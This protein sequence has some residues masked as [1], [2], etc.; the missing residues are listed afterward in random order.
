VIAMT[1][2]PA[3]AT[4]AEPAAALLRMLRVGVALCF[5]GHGA[6]GLMTKA[7]WVP[8]FTVAGVPET[9]AWRL[10]P[11]IGAMDV[12]VACL[13]LLWPCRALFV[14]AAGWATWTALLRPMAGQGWPEFFERAGNYGV[15]LAVLVIIGL[16]GPWLA[17]LPAVR[18][19]MSA[20]VRRRLIRV[21]QL[22]LASLLAGHAAC[23]LVLQKPALAHLYEVFGPS[24][25]VR[26]MLAAGWFEA[27][28]AF[29]VLIV[30]VPA[31]LV[32]ACLWKLTTESLFL[33]SGTP[34]PI[35]EII[36]RGGSYIVPL[37]LA[38]LLTRSTAVAPFRHPQ[39][40]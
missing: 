28:L 25:S 4:R 36:E 16:R 39:P 35:F 6:F 17:R 26:V 14:W 19:E 18:L 20:A 3:V 31:L 30:R 32:F 38:Y 13:V 21:L 34:A 33:T 24:D 40:C 27:V 1:E 22:V 11:W 7:A 37:A 23:A 2:Y 12:T 10:M 29:A 5:L 8:Y 9:G 15:P